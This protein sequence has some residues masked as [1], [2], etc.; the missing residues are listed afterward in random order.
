MRFPEVDPRLRA[1]V[2]LVVVGV[3]GLAAAP[4]P[5]VV[6]RA[7]LQNPV[8]AEEVRQWA[9]RLTAVG[10]A[11]TPKELGEQVLWWTE[12]IGG[13]HRAALAPFRPLFHATG[14]NQGWALF[15][16]PDNHPIR[17]QIRVRRAGS[18][19][20]EILFQR[21]DP[22]HAWHADLLAYRRVRGVYDAGGFRQKPR[23][24]YQRFARWIGHRALAEDPAI[25]AVEV[26]SLRT[27]TTL[28]GEPEDDTFEVR[29]VIEIRREP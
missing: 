1:V 20:W 25:E 11:V 24:N 19:D 6:T 22:E 18:P 4:I 21:L 5:H 13:A 10:L 8:S 9:A 27:H 28:P 3:H 2:L 17:L 29:H 26:R 15:A 23:P 7:D 14:T 16:N 12:R